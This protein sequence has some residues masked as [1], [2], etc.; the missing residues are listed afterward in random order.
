[1]VDWRNGSVTSGIPVPSSGGCDPAQQYRHGG[2]GGPYPVPGAMSGVLHHSQQQQ[3]QQVRRQTA[4]GYP[5]NAGPGYP[6]SVATAPGYGQPLGGIKTAAGQY[7]MG[8]EYGR[9]L[10]K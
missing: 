4:T 1:M 10:P 7:G 9:P 3:Q 5:G 2:Q 6:G 8:V